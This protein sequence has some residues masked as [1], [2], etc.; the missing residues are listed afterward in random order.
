MLLHFASPKLLNPTTF[1]RFKTI[2]P[3]FTTMT[4][5]LFPH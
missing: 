5:R 1:L 3:A 2:I 4:T